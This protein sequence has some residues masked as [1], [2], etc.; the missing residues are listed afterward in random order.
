MSDVE[1]ILTAVRGACLVLPEVVERVSH[2]APSWFVRGKK[3]FVSFADHV[4][5]DPHTAIWAAAP[6]GV[7]AELVAAE[8]ARFFV[9]P[10]VGHRGWLGLRLDLDGEDALDEIELRGIAAD[11]YRHIAPKTLARLLDV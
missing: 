3:T 9:P 4:H 11:A 8:P 6:P 7:T 2:G 5:G 1:R 10:Y